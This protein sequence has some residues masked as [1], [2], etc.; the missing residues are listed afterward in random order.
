MWSYAQEGRKDKGVN[1]HRSLKVVVVTV[2][3][4]A[5]FA[6]ASIAS[7]SSVL[8]SDTTTTG[9]TATTTTTTP[10]TV[11]VTVP[12]KATICHRTGSG[13]FVTITVSV[14]ALF[15]HFKHGDTPGPCTTAKVKAMK[16]AQKKAKSRAHHHR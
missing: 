6:V 14:N 13:K 16:A 15:A 12:A 4:A 10:T 2:L 11:T 8:G 1:V 5:G 9:T 3:A 7:G